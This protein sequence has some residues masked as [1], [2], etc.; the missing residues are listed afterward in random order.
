MTTAPDPGKYQVGGSLA[1]DTSMY[2]VRQA[3]DDLY[4]GLKA[5]EFCYVLN[6]RQIGKSSLMVQIMYQLQ[7]EGITCAVID[8][9]EIGSWD[10]TESQWYAGIAHK[11]VNNFNL[12]D[13]VDVG[14][15]WREHDSFSPTQRLSLL[16]EEV[17][18]AEGQKL[19]VFIDEIDS[20]LSLNFSID[21]F[22]EVIQ[23]CYSKRA[24]QLKYKDITFVLFGVTTPYELIDNKKRNLFNIGRKIELHGFKQIEA[25]PLQQGLIGKVKNSKV[26]LQK[27]LEWTGGQPFLTQKLCKLIQDLSCP[28][29]EGSEADWINNIVRSQVIENWEVREE[30]P[31][32]K[33]I[34]DRLI[35]HGQFTVRMLGIYQ[36]ILQVDEVAADGSIE[37]TELLLSGLVIRKQ[38]KL[39]VSNRIYKEVFSKD[40]V[41]RLLAQQRP[42]AEELAAWLAANRQN[43]AWLLRGRKLQYALNWAAEKNLTSEDYHFLNASQRWDR[44]ANVTRMRLAV[45]IIAIALLCGGRVLWWNSNSCSPTQVKS[46]DGTCVQ[47]E[48]ERFSSGERRL[49]RGTPNF[50]LDSG[51]EA[52]KSGNYPKAI[53]LFEKASDRNNPEPKIYLNNS[54]ARRLNISPFT[55]A[56]VVPI[57]NGST[58]AEEILRGVA[59]AQTKFNEAGGLNGRLLEIVIA[60]DGN[61]PEVAARIATQLA[62]MPAVL[63]VVGHN[64]SEATHAALPEYEKAEIAV[65]SSTSTS[66]SLKSQ[67]FFRTIISDEETGKKLAEYAKTKGLNRVVIF[68]DTQSLYSRSLRKAFKENFIQPGQRVVDGTDLRNFGLL[69]AKAEIKRRVNLDRVQAAVLLPSTETTS[70]AISL[71]RANAELLPGQRLQL[72]GGDALYAPE[73]VNKHNGAA[74]EGLILAVGWSDEVPSTKAY[75]KV[76]Y[77]TWRGKVSWSTAASY[78]AT[79][80]LIKSLSSNASRKTVLQNLKTVKLLPDQT[81]GAALQFLPIGDR[82]GKAYLVQVVRGAPSPSGSQFGFK[83]IE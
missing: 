72:L 10:I 26:A 38:E 73:T 15:W 12:S 75:A 28:I 25:K 27:V 53:G 6:S 61:Y 32:L 47:Q 69:D 41:E 46:N 22:F 21:G 78:D 39:R 63:G 35:N 57:D 36:Q 1:I 16:L 19:V 8:I 44:K 50:A 9:S 29:P 58:T 5:G 71:A 67:V 2:V 34:R 52:F 56:V 14:T 18:P 31:H 7:A 68:S 59:D 11:L 40:W 54:E 20:V 23:A 60:N 74:S 82:S 62:I 3:D 80:V 49:F 45:P 4:E 66:T 70:V 83:L 81:S 43:R 77:E 17:L 37:Q 24:H 13:R 42:Y 33:A 51:I 64:S 55:L 65:V 79:Q 30:P 48:P 76:A